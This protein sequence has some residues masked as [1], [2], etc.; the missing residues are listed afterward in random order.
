VL[1]AIAV[2]DNKVHFKHLMLYEFQK[3]NNATTASEN[4]YGEGVVSD[5]NCCKWFSRFCEENVALND[6]PHTACPSKVDN[7]QIHVLTG[8]DRHL[9]VQDI[10]TTLNVSKIQVTNHLTGMG[11]ISECD[12]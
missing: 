1:Q 4:I 12:V 9:A 5:R 7:H 11:V 10:A 2:R 6:E 8:N 3:E